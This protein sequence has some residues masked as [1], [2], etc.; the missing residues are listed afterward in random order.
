[1]EKGQQYGGQNGPPQDIPCPPYPGPAVGY[2]IQGD[3]IVNGQYRPP[4]DI[5][6]PPYPVPSVDYGIGGA[7]QPRVNPP[8]T[9]AGVA[10]S[11]NAP[12][13]TQVV[14]LQQQLPSNVSGQMKCP[15]CQIEV[16]TETTHTPGTHT[17]ML[18]LTLGILLCW[19][20]CFIPFCVKSC[21][22]VK[23]HCPNC[24]NVIHIHKAT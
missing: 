4:Q 13:I 14:V 10:P 15:H 5:S 6:Y 19:P 16:V 22:D 7:S 11:A 21:Q 8:T 23:H 24:K 9:G 20:C 12:V 3:S 1:M 2:G 17:W 18:C